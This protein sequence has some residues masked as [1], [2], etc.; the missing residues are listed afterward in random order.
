M[1]AQFCQEVMSDSILSKKQGFMARLEVTVG[2][3][4]DQIEANAMFEKA[5][6]IILLCS[7]I[8]CFICTENCDFDHAHFRCS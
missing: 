5:R 3:N 4:G 6:N 1:F 2:A 7:M 8:L